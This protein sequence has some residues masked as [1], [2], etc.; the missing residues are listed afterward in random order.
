V[1]EGRCKG[2]GSVTHSSFLK[3]KEAL[4]RLEAGAALTQISAKT[5]FLKAIN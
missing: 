5:Q 1:A 2:R 3:L 4:P